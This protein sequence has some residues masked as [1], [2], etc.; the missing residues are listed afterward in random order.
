[1]SHIES[2]PS[3]RS[4]SEYDF[5][6]DCEE[7]QGEKLQKFMD[8]LKKQALSIT[9]HSEDGGGMCDTV[10]SFP[11]GLTYITAKLCKGHLAPST[12]TSISITFYFQT[13]HF[14]S[15]PPCH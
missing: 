2:R 8:A 10:R 9:L 6:V 1:M 3:K 14:P 13:N 15:A 12:R 7:I 5:I 4:M 11:F